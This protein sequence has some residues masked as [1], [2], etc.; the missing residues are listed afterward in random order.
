MIQERRD[1]FEVKHCTLE[2]CERLIYAKGMCRAHYGRARYAEKKG[3]EFSPGPIQPHGGKRTDYTA[4]TEDGL[5]VCTRCKQAMSLD[6][7][8]RNR[9][10]PD[11]YSPFCRRCR[12]SHRS[13][14]YGI[15]EEALHELWESQDRKCPICK[16]SI[17]LIG[18]KV[19]GKYIRSASI[20]HDHTC[21]PGSKSCGECIRGLLCGS[22]N[23]GLGN[24]K[25]SIESLTNATL[26]LT[27]TRM[28]K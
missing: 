26:Y 25:D 3:L 24:F 5:K 28:L 2:E 14:Q 18:H 10:Y 12:E 23:H 22:C 8:N 15:S 9:R 6:W 20:D 1:T 21:C 16:D 17:E 19:D 27:R 11:G 13:Y 7:F 4:R